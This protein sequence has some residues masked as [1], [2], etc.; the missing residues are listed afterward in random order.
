MGGREG[1]EEK[2]EEGKEGREGREGREEE[3]WEGFVSQSMH[4]GKYYTMPLDIWCETW[5][6]E[7][8]CTAVVLLFM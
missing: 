8:K 2:E 3:G 7:V 1:K 4:S 6:G 5:E